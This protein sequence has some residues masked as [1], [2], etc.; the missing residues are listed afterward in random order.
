[1]AFLPRRTAA[2]HIAG[3]QGGHE[4]HRWWLKDSGSR[5]MREAMLLLPFQDLSC[6]S[7]KL[8]LGDSG[9]RAVAGCRALVHSCYGWMEDNAWVRP[10]PQQRITKRGRLTIP[11]GGFLPAMVYFIDRPHNVSNAP[12]AQENGSGETTGGLS[13]CQVGPILLALAS[14]A[15]RTHPGPDRSSLSVPASCFPRPPSLLSII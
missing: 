7:G 8:S 10:E 12:P 3:F 6:R 9:R 5:N 15:G 4:G 1:M 2:R 14:A 13:V 11:F